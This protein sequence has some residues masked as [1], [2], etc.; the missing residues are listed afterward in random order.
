M[1]LFPTIDFNKVHFFK[2][3]PLGLDVGQGAITT[4]S[5]GEQRVYVRSVSEASFC[6]TT[7]FRLFLIISHE[8][9]HVLQIHNGGSRLSWYP[10]YITCWIMAGFSSKSGNCYEEEAYTYADGLTSATGELKIALTSK[11]LP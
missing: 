10:R 1:C 3:I 2:G 4:E 7:K 5:L 8:L 6:Y 11:A 9:V